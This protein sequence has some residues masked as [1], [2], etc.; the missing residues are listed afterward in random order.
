MWRGREGN[1]PT[2]LFTRARGG[3]PKGAR[4]YRPNLRGTQ[5]FWPLLIQARND[6][7]E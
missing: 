4:K 7:G 3:R 1:V 6:S 5:E 2:D